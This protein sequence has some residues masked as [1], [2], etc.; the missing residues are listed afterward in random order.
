MSRFLVLALLASTF[1][2]FGFQGT[3]MAAPQAE[4]ASILIKCSTCGVDFTSKSASGQH[5]KGHS[6]H[7]VTTPTH[8]LIKCSTCGVDFTSH[9]SLKEHLQIN[10]DHQRGPLVICSTCGVEFTSPEL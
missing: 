2:I 9:V 4:D 10:P 5:M 6:E 3:L 7:K 8:P 1:I